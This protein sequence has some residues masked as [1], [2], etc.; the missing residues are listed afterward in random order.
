[1]KALPDNLPDELQPK[2]LLFLSADVVGST[3]LKQPD[4]RR[5]DKDAT[6]ADPEARTV[7]W[8]RLID[9]FYQKMGDSLRSHWDQLCRE[10]P[11]EDAMEQWL[12]PAPVFWKTIGDEIVFYKVLKD[13]LQVHGVL[14]CW[15]RTLASIRAFF[16]D[17]ATE[18][19]SAGQEPLDVKST[20]WC[21]G[22]PRR[23]KQ[24]IIRRASGQSIL[25]QNVED[26]TT[27]D[28]IGPGIDI[29]FRL[30]SLS[31][32]QKMVISLDVAYILAQSSPHKSI[33]D[34]DLPVYYD[35]RM[36]L[37]GVFRDK[38]YP[39][40]WMNV[41][42]PESFEEEEVNIQ[43]PIAA[44]DIRRICKR[45][46]DDHY[47]VFTHEPFIWGDKHYLGEVPDWFG[48]WLKEANEA[49]HRNHKRNEIVSKVVAHPISIA[50]D[51]PTE[52]RQNFAAEALEEI[53][54]KTDKL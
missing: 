16:A 14:E 41:S 23:N 35:G 9:S 39:V 50:D 34:T 49:Y 54:S 17:N 4:V 12:G 10:Q 43:R 26:I 31:S 22:F 24:V 15:I 7:D 11:N 2:L 13:S 32:V 53:R 33:R 21:A 30:S 28:F 42:P 48:S 19:T 37:K 8:L 40:F 29:G 25:D 27:V 6:T 51:A 47:R 20:V 38:R 3:A 18:L 44:A 45:F 5:G 52:S 1:V 46:Y 36:P